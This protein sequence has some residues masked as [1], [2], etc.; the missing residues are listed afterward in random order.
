MF[1]YV[2]DTVLKTLAIVL[3]RDVY[4]I[5]KTASIGTRAGQ[6]KVFSKSIEFGSI[7]R[8]RSVV[9]TPYLGIFDFDTMHAAMLD[10]NGIPWK[11]DDPSAPIIIS[12]NGM[13]GAGSHYSSSI[14]YEI[15]GGN[16]G[17]SC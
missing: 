17:P 8:G 6:V 12:H 11:R 10:G 3:G 1:P 9:H 5:N 16:T 2:G 14:L 7:T 4:Q 13:N 15:S